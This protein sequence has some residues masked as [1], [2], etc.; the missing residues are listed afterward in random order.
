[1]QAIPSLYLLD[2]DKRVIIKDGT[3]VAQIENAIAYF[4]AM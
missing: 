4:E 3:S 2:S 1:L